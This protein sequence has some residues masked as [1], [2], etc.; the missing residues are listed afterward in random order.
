MSP[1]ILFAARFVGPKAAKPVLIVLGVMLLIAVLGI[2][3]C[4]YDDHVIANH[5]A[6]Q[7]AKARPADARAAESRATTTATIAADKQEITNALAPLPDVP[8]TDRQRARYC[9][10]WLRQNPDAPANRRPDPC[11]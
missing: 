2:G 5:E 3:K 1:L 7:A 8:L 9:A 10:T 4:A 6:Q 11:R